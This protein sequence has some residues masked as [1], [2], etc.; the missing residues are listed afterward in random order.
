VYASCYQSWEKIFARLVN[1]DREREMRNLII[2]G[3]STI[4]FLTTTTAFAAERDIGKHSQDEIRKACNA[5]GGD[6]LGVSDSGSY[7]C[8]VSSNGTMILCNKNQ[9]CTGYTPL[10]TSADRRKL[11]G[12]LNL[13]A[14]RVI[15]R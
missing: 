13:S 4:A 6:L 7:G 10:R 1:P 14:T 5:A 2:A 8:E 15:S 3:V 9:D 11:L 12:A